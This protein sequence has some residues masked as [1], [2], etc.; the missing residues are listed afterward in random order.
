MI[1]IL[2]VV[3]VSMN[4]QPNVLWLSDVLTRVHAQ[5]PASNSEVTIRRMEV[6]TDI[7]LEFDSIPA[8]PGALS[9]DLILYFA[10]THSDS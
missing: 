10:K 9:L 7:T 5:V 3:H 2:I 8:P 4:I 1:H 6:K